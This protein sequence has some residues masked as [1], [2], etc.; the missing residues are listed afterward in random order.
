MALSDADVQK[1]VRPKSQ[2]PLAAPISA[3]LQHLE[4]RIVIDG[5]NSIILHPSD[6][7]HQKL[8]RGFKF[9]VIWIVKVQYS[10]H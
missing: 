6:H 3:L 5:Q 9:H 10:S 1:Q 4:Q 7:F 8:M 2:I